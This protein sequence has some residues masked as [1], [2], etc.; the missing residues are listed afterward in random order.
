MS[1]QGREKETSILLFQFQHLMQSWY[2]GKKVE[3]KFSGMFPTPN[4]F[5]EGTDD[6]RLGD[7]DKLHNISLL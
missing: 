2:Y 3:M 4:E 5:L 7:N 6:I 1:L